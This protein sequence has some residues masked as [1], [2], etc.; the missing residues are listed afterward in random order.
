MQGKQTSQSLRPKRTVN[1]IQLTGGNTKSL[2]PQNLPPKTETDQIKESIKNAQVWN[3]S[4]DMRAIRLLNISA[5]SDFKTIA[6][7]R[8]P[9]RRLYL[10]NKPK[11][12]DPLE[13]KKRYL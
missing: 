4:K 10:L 8:T 11:Q 1:S 12:E 2:E 3:S 6:A 5:L 7:N 13:K 9:G